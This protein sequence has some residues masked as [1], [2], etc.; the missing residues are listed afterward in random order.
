[1]ARET[2]TRLIDDLDGGEAVETVTFGLDGLY[3]EIDLSSKNANKLRTALS[4]YVEHGH[5]VA[6]RTSGAARGLRRRA[7][8]GGDRELNQAIRA[9]A[10]KRGMEVAPRGRIKQEIIDAYHKRSGR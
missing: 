6:G 1:L 5:R 9:W 3:Y 8:G 7:N 4:T 10:Q 2:I